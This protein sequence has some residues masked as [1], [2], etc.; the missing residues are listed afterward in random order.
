MRALRLYA[1]P[2]ARAD[3]ESAI[4]KAALWLGRAKPGDTEERTFQILG[5]VWGNPG[6]KAIA[7][8]ARELAAQQ[9][10]DG[11]WSQ[12]PTLASDAYATGQA[13]VALETSGGLAAA[14]PAYRRGVDFLLRTQLEDG[15]WL[16][17]TRA[18]AIMPYFESGFPHGPDQW[19]S[20][21]A[22]SWA[23]MALAL[24]LEPVP[25]PSQQ[26]ALPAS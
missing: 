7:K 23:T 25:P 22:T 5:L 19:I 24:T 3:F 26:P 9:R 20:A 10:A 4:Q 1:P 6:D 12:M 2:G 21:F 18:I 13:L 17:R 8:A 16:V 15:S 14:G 11:G